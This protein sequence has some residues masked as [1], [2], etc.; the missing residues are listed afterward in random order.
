MVVEEVMPL[1]KGNVGKSS[2]LYQPLNILGFYY[3]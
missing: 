3:V 2:Q 1:M